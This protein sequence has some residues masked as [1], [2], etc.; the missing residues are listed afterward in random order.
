V[1]TRILQAWCV[2]C[3][4]VVGSAVAIASPVDAG[5]AFQSQTSG[6][7]ERY[8]VSGAGGGG[9]FSVLT[10]SLESAVEIAGGEVVRRL[11]DAGVLVVELTANE[12]AVLSSFAG[13][14]VVPDVRVTIA[15]DLDPSESTTGNWGLD[16]LDQLDAVLDGTFRS[17]VGGE[18]VEIF[19]IDTGVDAAHPELA[20]RVGEGLDLVQDGNPAADCNGH[21]TLVASLAAGK[22][23]GPAR[24]AT[25]R[26]IRALDCDGSGWSSDVAAAVDW[27][28]THAVGPAVINLSVGGRPSAVLDD[29]IDRAVADG[30]VVVVAAGNSGGDACDSSPGR[31]ATALTVGSSTDVDV[32][33]A[34]S[35]T[36]QCVDIYAPGLAV[37]GATAGDPEGYSRASGTSASAPLVAGLAALV[38]GEDPTLSAGE[39]VDVLLGAASLDLRDRAASL[40]RSD[41][42]VVLR[43]AQLPRY[44]NGLLS[45]DPVIS[46]VGWGVLPATSDSVWTVVRFSG[47]PGVSALVSTDSSVTAIP[48]RARVGQDGFG[49]VG[50]VGTGGRQVLRIDGGHGPVEV[51]VD[52]VV[53]SLGS[54]VIV[55]TVIELGPG[56]LIVGLAVEGSDPDR[57]VRLSVN[58]GVQTLDLVTD[59]QAMVWL[60]TTAVE[61]ISI[62]NISRIDHQR[63]QTPSS[64]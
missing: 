42:E 21:G 59:A 18:G 6:D 9:D 55:S 7:V 14:S 64:R 38:L 63:G 43:L 48:R 36:G 17:T 33:A 54:G 30:F 10:V 52:S 23:V 15:S 3:L 58:N 26:P 2:A 5:N 32:V 24:F 60:P 62:N 37:L 35:D 44:L 12:L 46:T 16:R 4:V 1:S 20:G 45:F 27:A 13:V 19:V 53:L 8:V 39:V 34:F 28:R 57:R 61:K 56:D 29:A 51:V 50:W 47:T 22:T 31:S 11:G 25:V 40:D 41:P 49:T